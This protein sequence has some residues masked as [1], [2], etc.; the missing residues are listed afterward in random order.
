MVKKQ[1]IKKEVVFE[2]ITN[3]K[4]L[5]L[6][7]FKAERAWSFAMQMKDEKEDNPR[8]KF[9]VVRKFA[10]AAKHSAELEQL[11]NK[12]ADNRTILEA[13]AY[14][15]W[16]NGNFFLEHEDWAEAL[17]KF[18][19]AKT[20]Y[21]QLGKKGAYDEEEMYRTK[22]E[23]IEPSIRYCNY[24]LGAHTQEEANALIE[25]SLKSKGVGLD[26]LK[27]KLDDVLNEARKSESQQMREISWRGRTIQIRNEKLSVE[28]LA[29][30]E[31]YYEINKVEIY[32]KKLELFDKLF[33]NYNDAQRILRDDL[34]ELKK[35]IQQQKKKK[36]YKKEK[37]RK[38]GRES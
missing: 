2:T 7:L 23:E 4:Y 16:M 35:P 5:L 1:F 29:A 31:A 9:F 13:Q 8:V 33:I 10:K 25:M 12:R 32:D 36:I 15:C 3:D 19:R 37:K 27:A 21:E 18:V 17:E 11:C 30:Q 26:L 38:N 14:S 20:I 28:L 22:V 34:I 6:P 24:N